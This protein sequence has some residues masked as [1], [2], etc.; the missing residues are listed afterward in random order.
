MPGDEPANVAILRAA[1]AAWNR[2]DL[3]GVIDI[4]DPEVHW[5]LPEEGI[6]A[7]SYR[8]RAGVRKLVETYLDAFDSFRLEPERF[9]GTGD[10]IVVFLRMSVRGRGSGAEI[11]LR[12]AHVW[13]MRNGKALRMETFPRGEHALEAAGLD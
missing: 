7:G 9:V 3:N 11:E 2:N 4:L 13:T 6:N 8:G 1:Y 5:E 10:R 12:P